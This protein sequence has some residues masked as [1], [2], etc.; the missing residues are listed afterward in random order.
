MLMTPLNYGDRDLVLKEF[1]ATHGDRYDYSLSEFAGCYDY[2][3]IGCHVH[4]VFVQQTYEHRR[5]RGCPECGRIASRTYL[6]RRNRNTD[7]LSS[8][9]KIHSDRYDYS[10]I[11]FGVPIYSQ[12]RIDII[13]KQHGVFTT[14]VSIHT[15]GANCPKCAI[16]EKV[17]S[18]DLFISKATD[19]HGD[20][21][22]YSRVVYD[23]SFR[24]VELICKRHG[25]FLITPNNHL[26]GNGCPLC[27]SS[28]GE[29]RIALTLNRMGVV[30][31]V[32]KTFT[33]LR[34]LR[35]DFY[36]PSKNLLIEYDGKQ[37][38]EP[39]SYGVSKSIKASDHDRFL[40]QRR[41]DIKKN[42]YAERNCIRLIRIPY[43]GD[44]VEI[45]KESL[46]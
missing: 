15:S 24:K 4:G 10:L 43:Y 44:V 11:D 8:F 22:D 30:Y 5:G 27:I 31:E 19:L 34:R 6:V 3:K 21:Y 7:I 42:E 33:D 16:L 12:D 36:I 39:V 9:L 17:G 26:R 41:N 1:I 38:F 23:R 25:G 37:H 14:T 20:V 46:K 18:T 2:I 29:N 28:K 32:Q 13:C 40:K 35:F 45:L